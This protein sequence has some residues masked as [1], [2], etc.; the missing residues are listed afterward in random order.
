MDEEA[1]MSTSVHSSL[2]R[3]GGKSAWKNEKMELG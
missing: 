3:Q 1:K 2:G